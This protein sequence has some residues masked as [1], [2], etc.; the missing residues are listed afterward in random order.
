MG[1]LDETKGPT[2]VGEAPLAHVTETGR[3]H[4]LLEHLRNDQ[5][6]GAQP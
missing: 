5:L 4:L 1:E 2:E 3:P 6:L